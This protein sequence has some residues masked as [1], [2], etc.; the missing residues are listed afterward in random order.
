MDDGRAW[1]NGV[2]GATRRRLVARVIK[3]PVKPAFL[4]EMLRPAG[5]VRGRRGVPDIKNGRLLG[6]LE[7]KV[8]VGAVKQ[9]TVGGVE[10]RPVAIQACTIGGSVVNHI[11][12]H[13]VIEHE[14]R[15]QD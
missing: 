10:M 9:W 7:A 2:P 8:R 12:R 11:R 6:A 15:I 1:W 13:A 3:C 5:V 4:P 14:T